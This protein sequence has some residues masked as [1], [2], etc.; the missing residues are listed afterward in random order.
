MF[1][2]NHWLRPNG[3]PDPVEAGRVN[4]RKVLLDRFR[5]CGAA[6]KRLPDVLA[7]DFTAIGDLYKTVNELN[8]AIGTVSDAAPDIDKAIRKALRSGELS[9]ATARELRGYRRL[10]RVS[11]ARALKILGPVA[12]YVQR[13]SVLFAFECENGIAKDPSQCP[14]PK[15]TKKSKRS[16]SSST[17]TSTTTIAGDG[18]T[19]T[20][21]PAG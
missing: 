4:S 19:T 17:S 9:E 15:P 6:R 13:P 1:L 10:P 11:R 2:I 7:V 3:P 18:T 16:T 21:A 8:G 5:T 20:T 14:E 12:Q